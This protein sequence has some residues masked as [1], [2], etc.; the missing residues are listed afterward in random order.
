MICLVTMRESKDRNNQ[1]IDSIEHTYIDFFSKLGM[2]VVLSP[3]S[4]RNTV[5]LIK[6]LDIELV[7]LTGGGD[8]PEVDVEKGGKGI[9]PRRDENEFQ[10]FKFALEKQ[11]PIIAI[12]RGMQYVNSLLG[13]GITR[14]D[15]VNNSS[16]I[17]VDHNV[18]Y[19]STVLKVNNYHNFGVSM[20]NLSDKLNPLFIDEHRFVEGYYSKKHK[21]LGL[22]WHP[23]RDF[24][25]VH[26][27]TVSSE[28]VRK[29][30]EKKGELN[31]E[32]YYFSSRD[33]N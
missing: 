13:G 1:D 9:Q 12:C 25:S 2:T 33:G 28:I 19:G 21:I 26:A 8:I 29:F 11:I 18:F 6:G 14:F 10:I 15:G 32:G 27:K 23:E 31:Y 5:N 7:V 24:K 30:I 20:E 16:K 22:M 3:N 4:R 17:G